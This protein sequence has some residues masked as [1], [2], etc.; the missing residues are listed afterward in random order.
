[1]TFNPFTWLKRRRAER[2]RLLLQALLDHPE[3]LYGSDFVRLN[4]GTRWTVYEDLGRLERRG[5][6]REVL[7]PPQDPGLRLYRTRH[8]ITPAGRQVFFSR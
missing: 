1:M 7:E 6:I 5:Q 3:G 8:F 2:E 4:V